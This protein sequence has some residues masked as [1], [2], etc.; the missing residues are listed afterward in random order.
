MALELNEVH[1]ASNVRSGPA[2]AT[3]ASTLNIGTA[4]FNIAS[5]FFGLALIATGAMLMFEQNPRKSDDTS[6]A[7]HSPP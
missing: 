6:T 2:T 3:I 7:L 4:G 5:A 1:A